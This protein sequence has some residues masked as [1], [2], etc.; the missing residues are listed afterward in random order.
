M[1]V[2]VEPV[3]Y[4]RTT[5]SMAKMSHCRPITH[6]PCGEHKTWFGTMCFVCSNHLISVAAA[7]VAAAAMGVEVVVAAVI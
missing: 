6:D 7:A 5:N 4:P 3:M 2:E 1:E